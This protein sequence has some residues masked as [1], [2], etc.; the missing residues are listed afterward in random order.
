MFYYKLWQSLE[1]CDLEAAIGLAFRVFVDDLAC[2]PRKA[3]GQSFEAACCYLN[4]RFIRRIIR[5]RVAKA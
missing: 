2:Q 1:R 4:D 3:S 5:D